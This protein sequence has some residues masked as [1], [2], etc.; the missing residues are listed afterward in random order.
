MK[1]REEVDRVIIS[2]QDEFSYVSYE[3]I[4]QLTYLDQVL[5]ETLRFHPVVTG[6]SRINTED[7]QL[8]EYL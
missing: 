2:D 1:C 4:S 8:G 3:N 6:V 7:V 5:K